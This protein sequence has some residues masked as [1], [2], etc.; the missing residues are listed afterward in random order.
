MLKPRESTMVTGKIPVAE[1][2]IQLLHR[3]SKITKAKS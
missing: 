3:T 2:V 1:T